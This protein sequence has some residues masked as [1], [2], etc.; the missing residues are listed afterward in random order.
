MSLTEIIEEKQCRVERGV[1]K[2]EDLFGLEYVAR[3]RI[4]EAYGYDANGY[5]IEG[6]D[7]NGYDTDGNDVDGYSNDFHTLLKDFRKGVVEFNN[8]CPKSKATRNR[9]EKLEDN[10][11]IVKDSDLLKYEE[12]AMDIKNIKDRPK[13]FLI[14]LY[15]NQG[16]ITFLKKKKRGSNA[17]NWKNLN[18][19]DYICLSL[20]KAD[21]IYQNLGKASSL[22]TGKPG[23]W[24]N[25]PI[26]GYQ[27]IAI[28]ERGQQCCKSNCGTSNLCTQHHKLYKD[29]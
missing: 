9:E 8:I 24:I 22:K 13:Q 4:Y 21:N 11:W 17:K 27:C 7:A 18:K 6:Y 19:E 20:H 10:S 23:S 14:N 12:I 2:E 15:S 5:D 25:K 3:K 26:P 29:K 28:T 1:L 16:Y